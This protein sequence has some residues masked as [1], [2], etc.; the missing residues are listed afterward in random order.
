VGRPRSQRGGIG[1]ACAATRPRALGTSGI[2]VDTL[3]GALWD[4]RGHDLL[5][6]PLTRAGMSTVTDLGYSE[7]RQWDEPGHAG[8]IVDVTRSYLESAQ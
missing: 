8:G 2:T 7:S 4:I 5:G 1:L 3:G 6:Y